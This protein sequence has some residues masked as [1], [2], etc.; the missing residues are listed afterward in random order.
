MIAKAG[1]Q[2]ALGAGPVDGAGPFD[3][4]PFACSGALIG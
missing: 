3:D 1:A 2:S 4:T